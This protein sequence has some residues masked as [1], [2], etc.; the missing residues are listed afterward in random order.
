MLSSPLSILDTA[1]QART[2]VPASTEDPCI[3][4]FDADLRALADYLSSD[5]CP[6]V[7]M[8]LSELDG[9]LTA[10]AIGPDRIQP[11]EWTAP[12]WEGE[13]PVFDDDAEA[14]MVMRGLMSRYDAIVRDAPDGMLEP[15]VLQEGDGSV[16]ADAWAA[17]FGRGVALR[18]NAWKPLVKSALGQTMLLPILAA[19]RG[20][21]IATDLGL[22]ETEAE[23]VRETI[24]LL[25]IFVMGIARFWRQR[26]P[27]GRGGP[28]A[29][30][31]G[32]ATRSS[33][34]IGRNDPCP[35][36]SGTKF[37]KCCGG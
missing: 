2:S 11:S 23:L 18:V 8:T 14:Q 22:N 3:D 24:G 7:S 4:I 13:T 9:F 29:Q 37:K 27:A 5:R 36:G 21:K 35:C 16:R 15:L 30:R 1:E 10:V 32:S 31:I 20:D 28:L 19:G 34:K 26:G 17:G 33:P 25:P 12:I 6:P